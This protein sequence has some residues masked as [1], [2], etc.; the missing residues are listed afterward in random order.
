MSFL[1]LQFLF[2]YPFLSIG[3]I[4]ILNLFIPSL[5]L[6]SFDWNLV[7]PF[8]D[9]HLLNTSY[10]QSSPFYMLYVTNPLTFTAFIEPAFLSQ[11]SWVIQIL[12]GPHFWAKVMQLFSVHQMQGSA[13]Y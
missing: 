3:H 7:L 11:A 6:I 9:K 4:W 13:H 2:I 1:S 5:F 12:K 8:M 10:V